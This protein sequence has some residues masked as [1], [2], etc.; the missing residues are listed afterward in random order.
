MPVN[1]QRQALSDEVL[2]ITVYS[3][4]EL[5][6]QVV[7]MALVD[8]GTEPSGGDFAAV[9]WIGAAGTVRT[10]QKASAAYTAGSYDIYIRVTDDEIPVLYAGRMLVV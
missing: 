7:E 1:I 2:Q 6:D 10:A 9:S 4:V 5:D 8:A 3:P